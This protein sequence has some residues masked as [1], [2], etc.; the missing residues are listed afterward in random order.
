MYNREIDG[1]ETNPKKWSTTIVSKHIPSG[2]SMSTITS[3]K[4][5]ENKH[6]YRAKDCMKKFCEFVR[7]QAMKIISFFFKK[8]EVINKRAPGIIW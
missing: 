7:E 2:L 5:I 8:N 3:F 4:S 6:M 1:C